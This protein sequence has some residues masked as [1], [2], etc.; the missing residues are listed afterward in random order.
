MW[1]WLKREGSRR[2]WVW[3]QGEENW[4]RVLAPECWSWERSLPSE[5]PVK[6]REVR[7]S[8]LRPWMGNR[9]DQLDL[10]PGHFS[11]NTDPQGA[12]ASLQRTPSH[13]RHGHPISPGR[14][15]AWV[16]SHPV[17]LPGSWFQVSQGDLVQPPVHYLHVA[18][19]ERPWF[20]WSYEGPSTANK[21]VE[22]WRNKSWHFSVSK[23]T[24]HSHARKR[25]K[26]NQQRW[27]NRFRSPKYWIF[28]RNLDSLTKTIW[29][30]SFAMLKCEDM[31]WIW[32][33]CKKI[34]VF[35]HE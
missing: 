4:S 11:E 12:T 3:N 19:P 35:H 23:M 22:H 14:N 25:G 10:F 13:P 17:Y 20:S 30:L 16:T 1:A 29:S 27:P 8:Q 34:A 2:T 26:T 9:L 7:A 18:S 5:R 21:C 24:K 32:W 33:L 6:A 31:M 28:L 15:G